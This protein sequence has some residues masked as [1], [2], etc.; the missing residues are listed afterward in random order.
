MRM[1]VPLANQ[2][3]AD[4][5]GPGGLPRYDT[6]EDAAAARKQYLRAY[7]YLYSRTP[8]ARASGRVRDAD[9]VNRKEHRKRRNRPPGM[10]RWYQN[11]LTADH[12]KCYYCD[13]EVPKEERVGDHFEPLSKGGEHCVDNLVP[14]CK[15]C[16]QDKSDM[17]P[18][19]FITKRYLEQQ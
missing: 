7:A 19:D 18:G 2:I 1:T 15:Q 10:T 14:A 8:L 13:R 12:V 5:A 6:P 17:M 11:L 3:L 16:N 9:P 4:Y